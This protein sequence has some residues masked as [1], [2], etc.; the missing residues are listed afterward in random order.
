MKKKTIFNKK[1]TMLIKGKESNDGNENNNNEDLFKKPKFYNSKKLIHI[2]HENYANDFTE[3]R[4]VTEEFNN[5]ALSN[6][7]DYHQLSQYVID[8]LVNKKSS[9]YE[10]TDKN[11]DILKTYLNILPNFI[12]SI[13]QMCIRDSR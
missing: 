4:Q 8:L 12:N 13:K 2:S 3:F 7:T 11:L 9:K 5:H 1:S 10:V 6:I